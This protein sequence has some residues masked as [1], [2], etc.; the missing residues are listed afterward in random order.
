MLIQKRPRG[1]IAIAFLNMIA[2]VG[3]FFAGSVL[4]SLQPQLSDASKTIIGGIPSVGMANVLIGFGI[5]YLIL[6]F[7]LLKGKT[8]A[9]GI[10]IAL[11]FIGI[12]LGVMSIISENMQGIIS[13]IINPV[14]LYYLFKPQVKTYFGRKIKESSVLAET[15][16]AGI[17]ENTDLR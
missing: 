12:P 8:W 5:T 2:S 17:S 9:W 15:V 3:M 10:T 11:M 1:V 6:A 13:L 4:V 16:T 14:V 7:G